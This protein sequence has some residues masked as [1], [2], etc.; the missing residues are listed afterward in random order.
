MQGPVPATLH[1]ATVLPTAAS[2]KS[3][4]DTNHPVLID[5]APAPI[6]PQVMAPA[7]PWLPPAHQDIPGSIWLP[8]AGSAVLKADRGAAFLRVVQS[9]AARDRAVM[10]YCHPNCWASWNVTK[11]LLSNGYEHVAWFPPGIE[12]WA[13]AEFE[14]QQTVAVTY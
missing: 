4:I 9:H 11:F 5:V 1:G 14:L 2:A 10:V 3:W 8:G 12:G 6:R 13:E 7:M